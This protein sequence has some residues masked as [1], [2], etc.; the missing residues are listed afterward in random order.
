MK[1]HV[2]AQFL[3]LM[4]LVFSTQNLIAW[5]GIA[6]IL[7][8]IFAETG[9]LLGLVIPGGETLVFTSGLLVSTGVLDISIGLF[10]LLMVITAYLGDCSGYYFGKNF[11]KKLYTKKDSWYFKKQYLLMTEAYLHKHKKRSIII[12]KF[13]PVIRPFTPLISGI[14]K[15]NLSVFLPLSAVAVIIYLAAFLFAGYYL[16]QR[17]PQLKDYLGW[18]LPITVV[19]LLL[20][21]LLKFRKSTTASKK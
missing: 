15:L 11:G 19:V 13:F 17:F 12:G 8:L 10:Y 2:V 14:T 3:S 9:L 7:V 6:I 21:V 5:G 1:V 16:G 4:E 20:P 18:I